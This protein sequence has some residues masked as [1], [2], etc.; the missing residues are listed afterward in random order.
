MERKKINSFLIGAQKAG[1]TTL[2]SWLS[3]HPEINAPESTKDFHFFTSKEYFPKGYHW[4]ESLFGQDDTKQRLH[5]AVNY[6]FREDAAREIAKY[7][8]D[9]KLIV[10]L[11]DPVKRAFSAYQFFKK[12]GS[13]S[14]S[15]QKALQGEEKLQ[16]A[17]EKDDYAYLSHGCYARQIE[18]WLKYFKE[19]QFLILIFEEVFREPKIYLP[20]VF[21][22]LGVN[23]EFIPDL[24]KK[25]VSG[26]VKYKALNKL[27]YDER[28][29]LKRVLNKTGA[30][31]LFPMRWRGNLLTKFRD[32]NTKKGSV[33]AKLS[34][35]EYEHLK[36]YFKEDIRRLSNIMDKDLE[37]IWKY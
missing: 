12:L 4:F 36:P 15:F 5:G 6:I 30:K 21:N 1:S 25:N 27:I 22:F 20:K 19:D 17:E 37:N 26:E 10:V 7:N 32:L 8:P 9:A 23:P 33:S 35:E 34:K 31:H 24:E 29:V 13:E 2:F 11:R 18:T 16:T 14:R 28:S 3:Q